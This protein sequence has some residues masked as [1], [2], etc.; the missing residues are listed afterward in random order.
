MRVWVIDLS[1]QDYKQNT[2]L[3]V[4]ELELRVVVSYPVWGLRTKLWS[5]AREQVLFTAE[6]SLQHREHSF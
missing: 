2:V 6:L 4:L 5:S 1:P 3:D